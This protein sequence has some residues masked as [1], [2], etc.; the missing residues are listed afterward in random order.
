[1]KKTTL[2]I[3]QRLNRQPPF[4]SRFYPIYNQEIMSKIFRPLILSKKVIT[5][6]DDVFTQ[7]QT[8]NEMFLALDKYIEYYLEKL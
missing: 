6:L 7:S 2:T 1:M 8:K 4:S 3:F 5:C